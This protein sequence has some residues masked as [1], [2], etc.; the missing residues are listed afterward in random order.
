MQQSSIGDRRDDLQMVRF[1]KRLERS[2]VSLA[3]TKHLGKLGRGEIV[4]IT[5]ARGI[6]DVADERPD[7]G[8]LSQGKTYDYV[9]GLSRWQRVNGFQASRKIQNV[10]RQR[11][12]TRS[13]VSHA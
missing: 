7:F 4:T 8:W 3:G 9:Q 13:A 5:G 12:A 1:F 11:L 10:T 2:V 6:V